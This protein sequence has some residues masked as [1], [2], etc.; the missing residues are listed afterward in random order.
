MASR[1]TTPLRRVS[2]GSISS[3][4]LSRS[5]AGSAPTARSAGATPLAFLDAALADLGDETAVLQ[6]NLEAVSGIA[7]A[8][9]TFDES[10][11]MFLYGLRM[12]A[13]CTEWAEAPAEDNFER[14]G[15]R[16]AKLQ[17]ELLARSALRTSGGPGASTAAGY[18]SPPDDGGNVGDQTYMTSDDVSFGPPTPKAAPALKP[19]LKKPAA[20]GARPAAAAPAGAKKAAPK[21]KISLALRKKRTEAAA[22]IIDTLPLEYRGADPKPRALAENVLLALMAGGDD[23]VRIADMLAPPEMTQARINKT[24]IALVAA[25]HVVKTSN[26]GI[27]YH[28]DPARH[29]SIP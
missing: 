2:R 19:A 15:E 18:S 29:P 27:V 14:A 8:L 13:F 10:F 16:G 5:G 28:L 1:P 9:R 23:G 3:L 4:R 21:G 26:N 24:L 20:A 22:Q 12:N 7:A 17:S 6:A 25:K 11:S